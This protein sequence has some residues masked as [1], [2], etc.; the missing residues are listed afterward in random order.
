MLLF[1]FLFAL[2]SPVIDLVLV[3]SIAADLWDYYTRFSLELSG[4]TWNVL[5]YWLMFQTLEL[6]VGALAFR[7]DRRDGQ[8]SLLPLMVLQRF[9]YRQLIYWV[10][11]KAAAA[12][13]RGGVMGWGKLQRR[14]LAEIDSSAGAPQ[15]ASVGDASTKS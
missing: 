2:L 5:T 13:I 8:W 15:L 9:C 11:L 10:A 6:A 1:Q 4:G 14:G 7:L 3:L 12:A